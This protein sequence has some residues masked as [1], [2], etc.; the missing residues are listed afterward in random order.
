[1]NKI[2]PG[3]KKIAKTERNLDANFVTAV[4]FDEFRFVK[5]TSVL[6]IYNKKHL[7]LY[8]K[9]QSDNKF[10]EYAT[11]I[12]IP[13]LKFFLNQEISTYLVVSGRFLKMARLYKPEIIKLIKKLLNQ[14]LIELVAD[15]YNGES[16]SS[17]YLGDWWVNGL[18]KTCSE[19]ENIFRIKPKKAHIIQLFRSLEL[20]K[21]V[22]ATGIT[23]FLLPQ[24][25]K[26]YLDLSYKLADFRKFNGDKVSWLKGDR[27]YECNFKFIPESSFFQANGNIFQ[28]NLA[29]ATKTF[30]LA[31]GFESNEYQI[32]LAN[33]KI[34]VVR[35]QL[36]FAEKPSYSNFTDMEKALLRLWKYG[37]TKINNHQMVFSDEMG[38][39][40]VIKDFIAIH[41]REFLF[42]FSK[43]LY[44]EKKVTPFSSPYEALATVQAV[45][46]KLELFLE[47]G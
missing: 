15:S 45:I 14:N 26:K 1:M 23:D 46:A 36:R 32:R 17:L 31:V 19:I 18:V 30:A 29:L 16:F 41:S 34:R 38:T 10:K 8:D 33:K 2:S 9:I 7:G 35:N 11:K 27:N 44:L 37:L 39:K 21:V 47:K 5:P 24:K 40:E 12:Y 43:N 4:V 25:G 13:T 22:E 28:Q 3:S 20:E 6:E 42:Y